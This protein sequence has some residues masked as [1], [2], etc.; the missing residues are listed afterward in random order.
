MARGDTH[1]VAA[2]C[3]R[4]RALGLVCDA[5]ITYNVLPYPR[6][7]S[8]YGK[9]TAT[10]RA[11]RDAIDGDM[12]TVLAVNVSAFQLDVARA[13]GAAA[14]DSLPYVQAAAMVGAAT[15]V[16]W[17]L[18]H[19]DSKWTIMATVRQ[20][21]D[22]LVVSVLVRRRCLADP[23]RTVVALTLAGRASCALSV[24]SAYPGALGRAVDLLLHLSIDRGDPMLVDAAAVICAGA[25]LSCAHM[26]DDAAARAPL[27]VLL[28]MARHGGARCTR[29]GVAAAMRRLHGVVM[30]HLYQNRATLCEP[31]VF[32]VSTRARRDVPGSALS[33]RL[34]VPA[35]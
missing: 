9:P 35:T 30:D 11:I 16:D 7:M 31:D 4:R 5:G 22:P 18:E 27:P 29:R 10:S 1:G 14:R 6:N 20:S 21:A 24:I 2:L 25:T 33:T 17:A 19:T 12:V 34:P 32:D 26:M 15:T 8:G 28:A 3:E 23:M 13:A